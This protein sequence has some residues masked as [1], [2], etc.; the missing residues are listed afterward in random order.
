MSDA[1]LSPK[2]AARAAPALPVLDRLAAAITADP[3]SAR[4]RFSVQSRQIRGLH[5]EVEVRDFLLS[6]DEPPA[7][8]GTDRGP[9]PVELVLAAIA[10]CQEIT[11]RLYADRLGIPLRGVSVA[12]EGT[13]DLRGFSALEPGVR[14]GLQGLEIRVDLDSDACDAELARLKRTVDAHC[15]V[16]D[17]L[18]NETPVA[19]RFAEPEGGRES[20]VPEGAAL[21][22]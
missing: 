12:V 2:P 5:S 4:A 8:G 18:C 19:T 9:N 7:L 11:Y 17:I 3:P 1:T 22:G 6:V 15:P 20:A 14:P 13:L 16:L 10:S 21:A